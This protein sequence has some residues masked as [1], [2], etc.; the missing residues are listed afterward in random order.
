MPAF[1]W[2][3][4]CAF[5]QAATCCS[6]PWR[7]CWRTL[8]ASRTT[9]QSDLYVQVLPW[10]M[11]GWSCWP[12]TGGCSGWQPSYCLLFTHL[13][14]VEPA[15]LRSVPVHCPRGPS[16]LASVLSLAAAVCL[17]VWTGPT[18]TVCFPRCGP[19]RSVV[20]CAGHWSVGRFGSTP[21][22]LHTAVWSHGQPAA[23][24]AACMA[25]AEL[26]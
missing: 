20:Y 6:S 5:E 15:L 8:A 19:C 11:S 21:E 12:R 24:Q 2:A 17:A 3:F 9:F 4:C 13:C 23:G 18:K 7:A 16:A 25:P 26:P 14:A 22:R 1:G 10:C